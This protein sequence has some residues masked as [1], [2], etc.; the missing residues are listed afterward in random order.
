MDTACFVS[1]AGKKAQV[2]GKKILVIDDVFTTGTTL[3][4]AAYVLRKAGAKRVS[5]FALAHQV[6]PS[7][8]RE[9][10]EAHEE[11]GEVNP[12]LLHLRV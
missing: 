8:K 6:M 2:D 11:S 12:L 9:C 4:L 3:D 1:F 7:F 10:E 5:I